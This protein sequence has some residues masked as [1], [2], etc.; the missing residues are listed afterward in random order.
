MKH[1]GVRRVVGRLFRGAAY[2]GIT[3]IDRIARWRDDAILP[4]AHLRIYYYRTWD[5]KRFARACEDA[6][7]E[8]ML[9]G[10]QPEH[11]VLDVG[12]GIGNLALGL[13]GYLRGG[14]DGVEIHREAVEWC[15]REI[16]PRHPQFRFHRADIVSRAYNPRGGVSARGYRFPFHDHSFDF[17]LL[18]SVFTHMLPDQVEHYVAEISRLLKPGGVC[19]ASYF[20]LNDESRAGVEAGRSFMTFHVPHTSGV[21]RLHD[22]AVP[23][24]AV[25]FEETF[26]RAIHQRAGLRVRDL[27]RGKWWS[28]VAHDQDVLAVT[29]NVS[30][31]S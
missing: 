26:V 27:R 10:L 28:G 15:Q 31:P 1:S 11:R 3:L 13:V 16:T 30:P 6:R 4:P 23:E 17:I 12:S 20:L 19:V 14:Y 25:A 2:R 8:L 21:C 18:A 7:T 9:Q 22:E 29:P 24:A 5:R